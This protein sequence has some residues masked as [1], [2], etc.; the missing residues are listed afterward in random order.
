MKL[1][2]CST[3]SFVFWGL[4]LFDILGGFLEILC[5]PHLPNS[6]GLGLPH[7]DIFCGFILRAALF[8]ISYLILWT[9]VFFCL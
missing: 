8:A 7:V 9:I 4:P 5:G 3:L 2:K 1:M 6:Y